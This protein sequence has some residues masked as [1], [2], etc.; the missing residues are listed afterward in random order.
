MKQKFQMAK[1]V[2]DPHKVELAGINAC[3][4]CDF[5]RDTPSFY[6]SHLIRAYIHAKCNSQ[7]GK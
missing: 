4:N 1:L 6:L 5:P 2:Q 7:I 3:C